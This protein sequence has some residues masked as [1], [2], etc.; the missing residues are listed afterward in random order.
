MGRV[1]I[2][3]VAVGWCVKGVGMQ[4]SRSAR[5]VGRW[6]GICKVLSRIWVWVRVA[7]TGGGG[8]MGGHGDGRR[9]W[10]ALV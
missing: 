7:S 8:G 9:D 3:A 6:R 5:C 2:V 1:W 4:G 10:T